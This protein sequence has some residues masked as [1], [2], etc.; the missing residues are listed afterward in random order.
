M[1][2]FNI[3]TAYAIYHFF[4]ALFQN[5]L[6]IYNKKIILK[7]NKTNEVKLM[8]KKKKNCYIE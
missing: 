4:Q 2:Y 8:G 6:H 5:Y 7:S 3:S 1:L